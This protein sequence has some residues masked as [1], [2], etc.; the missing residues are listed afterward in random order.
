MAAP[1][2][3][4]KQ[5]STGPRRNQNPV[6]KEAV[7]DALAGVEVQKMKSV[8]WPSA[9]PN[10]RIL[11]VPRGLPHNSCKSRTL[12]DLFLKFRCDRPAL[13][14]A[15]DAMI[16]TRDQSGAAASPAGRRCAL[17]APPLFENCLDSKK[18][19]SVRPHATASSIDSKRAPASQTIADWRRLSHALHA[20]VASEARGGNRMLPCRL[21]C[22]SSTGSR[23]LFTGRFYPHFLRTKVFWLFW[24]FDLIWYRES[25]NLSPA[26]LLLFGWSWEYL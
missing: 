15:R 18:G 25:F 26:A 11:S 13:I 2:D 4:R 22:R 1:V 9:V 21:H 20:V 10:A 8:C 5:T 23:S 17:A 7:N 12:F 19:F 16:S 14:T 3:G 24:T 6:T